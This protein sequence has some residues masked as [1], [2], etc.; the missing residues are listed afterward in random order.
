MKRIV[1]PQQTVG[2][3]FSFGLRVIP[4]LP[5][6]DIPGERVAITG[7]VLDGQGQPVSDAVIEVWQANSRGK[8]DHPEDDQDKQTTPGFT[9]FGR[10][11]TDPRGGFRLETIKPGPVPWIEGGQQAPHINVSVFARGLLR[12]LATRVYFADEPATATDP[13]LALIADDA[14]RDTLLAQPDPREPGVY[15]WNVVLKGERETVFFDL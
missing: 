14:R 5:S 3:Y 6:Q 2:P 4:V 1:T 12:H 7:R 9:G 11:F 8:Y 13:V 10:L 15:L